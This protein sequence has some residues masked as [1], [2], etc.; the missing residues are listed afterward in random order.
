MCTYGVEEFRRILCFQLNRHW[1]SRCVAEYECGVAWGIRS[2]FIEIAQEQVRYSWSSRS[3]MFSRMINSPY[4]SHHLCHQL[5]NVGPA[6]LLHSICSETTF[7]LVS[8]HFPAACSFS[9]SQSSVHQQ[10]VTGRDLHHM[11]WHCP[12]KT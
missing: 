6:L 8:I 9:C 1:F 7:H 11:T 10:Q 12:K 5:F 2:L 3:G 4:I